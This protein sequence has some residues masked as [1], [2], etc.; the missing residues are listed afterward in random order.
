MKPDPDAQPTRQPSG[1]ES[2][3]PP[4]PRRLLIVT[5]LAVFLGE[6]LVMLL[7]AVLPPMATIVEALADGAMITALAAP[8][9]YLFLFR[10]MQEHIQVRTKAEQ[11]SRTLNDRL[12]ALVAERTEDLTQTN[13]RLSREIEEHRRTADSLRRNNEFI[14]RVVEQ[15]PCLVLTF[16]VD[17][18]RCSYV[19]SRVTD[20][21]GYGQDELAVAK[22][23]LIQGL[24]DARDRSSFRETMHDLVNGPEGHVAR[25]TCGFIASTGKVVPLRFEMTVLGRTPTMEAKDVLLAAMAASA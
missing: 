15:A 25:G 6:F 11:E 3:R 21:L 10:P 9:L 14:E 19:N 4:S 8:F 12:E 7:L 20:L 24:I 23:N 22:D 2:K 18:Q 5:A 1:D 17:S 16:D 13:R